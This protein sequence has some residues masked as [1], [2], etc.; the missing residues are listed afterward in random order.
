M[1]MTA[2]VHK[3]VDQMPEDKSPF[4]VYDMAG[5]VSEWTDTLVPGSK[6]SLGTV[7]VIR[8]GNLATSIEDHAMVI[9]RNTDW[10]QT[11]RDFWLG[12]RCVSDTPPK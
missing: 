9:Y 8:G 10:P 2:H 7:A 4:G 5:N 3:A 6:P 1:P 11:T 12:F